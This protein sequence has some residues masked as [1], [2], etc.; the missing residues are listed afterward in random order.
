[1]TFLRPFGFRRILLDRVKLV[2]TFMPS[3]LTYLGT[4]TGS[5]PYS[6]FPSESLTPFVDSG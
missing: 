1:M 3:S 2:R 4:T 6:G 5:V